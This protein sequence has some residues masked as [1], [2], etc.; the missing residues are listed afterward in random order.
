MRSWIGVIVRIAEEKSIAGRWHL[1]EKLLLFSY[2]SLAQYPDVMVLR[3]L[4]LLFTAAVLLWSVTPAMAA[5]QDTSK[6][7]LCPKP[8]YPRRALQ[9]EE[10]GISVIGFLIRADGTVGR[11]VILNSSGFADLD[12]AAADTLSKCVF[13]PATNGGV[14]TESWAP[15]AYNW[16]IGYDPAMIRRRHDLAIA[17]DKGDVAARYHLSL[18]LS[19]NA[20]NDAERDLALVLL[21]TAAERGHAHAQF[22]LGRRYE[23]GTGGHA[24]IE[25]A[26][27]WYQKA[28]AQG[29][30]LAIQRLR[31]GSLME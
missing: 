28:A 24:D 26:L 23:K 22:D 19:I 12:Q 29:D 18:I 7:A 8:I 3:D 20:N 2:L 4:R 14:A 1:P 15:V 25:E 17:A 16:F 6:P 10:E 9:R 13:K 5:D 30:V 11:T 21:R 31:V 27:R